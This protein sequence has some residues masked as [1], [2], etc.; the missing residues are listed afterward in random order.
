M[1]RKV[2]VNSVIHPLTAI[3]GCRNGELFKTA[4]AH[5]VRRVVC[6]EAASVFEAQALAEAEVHQGEGGTWSRQRMSRILTREALDEE[7][8]RIVNHSKENISTMLFDVRRGRRTE[9]EFL[10]G[11]LVGLGTAYKVQMPGNRMLMNLVKMRSAI[12]LD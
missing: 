11:Y 7:C 6:A 4:A 1:K 9:I 8:L 5:D 2:A 12:P 10:N 3:M